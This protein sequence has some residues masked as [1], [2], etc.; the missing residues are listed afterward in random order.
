LFLR[1]RYR[2]HHSRFFPR[3][4]LTSPL[5]VS[6]ISHLIFEPFFFFFSSNV[7]KP[8]VIPSQ[9]CLSPPHHHNCSPDPPGFFFFPPPLRFFFPLFKPKCCSSLFDPSVSPNLRLFLFWSSPQPKSGVMDIGCCVPLPL[10]AQVKGLFYKLR[11]EGCSRWSL[12]RLPPL[13]SL[14]TVAGIS[15]ARTSPFASLRLSFSILHR[16]KYAMPFFPLG[17][18]FH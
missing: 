1:C 5:D 7:W 9:F 2:R 6:R 15:L 8:I 13:K 16:A 18:F 4:S 3:A 14:P 10:G 17:S 12:F 11:T